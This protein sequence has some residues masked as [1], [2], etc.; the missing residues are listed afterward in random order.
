MELELEKKVTIVN[1]INE[2]TYCNVNTKKT[3]ILHLIVTCLQVVCCFF[4]LQAKCLIFFL[5][6]EVLQINLEPCYCC[7]FFCLE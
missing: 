5:Q 7:L 2:G 4:F 1:E 3:N 6:M